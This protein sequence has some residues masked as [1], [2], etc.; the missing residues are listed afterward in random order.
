MANTPPLIAT[1]EEQELLKQK[2]ASFLNLLNVLEANFPKNDHNYNTVSEIRRRLIAAAEYFDQL[3]NEETQTNFLDAFNS[4]MKSAHYKVEHLRATSYYQSIFTVI[5]DRIRQI[6]VD[7]LPAELVPELHQFQVQTKPLS[8][9][10]STRPRR[11]TLFSYDKIAEHTAI[12]DAVTIAVERYNKWYQHEQHK[13]P[14]ADSFRAKRGFFT[15]LRHG[16]AGQDRAKNL[17]AAV[18]ESQNYTEAK[19]LVNNFLLGKEKSTRYEVHS[20]SSFLLDQLATIKRLP[21]YGLKDDAV[22]HRYDK[23]QVEDK[24]V[25]RKSKPSQGP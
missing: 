8:P 24:I 17:E 21:W 3:P 20:F 19:N 25:G 14:K 9:A 1:S 22:T 16:K 2:K 4:L 11:N 12:I 10:P 6:F 23:K 13:H 5:L 15:M 18:A 7:E